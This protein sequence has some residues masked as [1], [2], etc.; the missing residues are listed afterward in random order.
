M[1]CDP[2]NDGFFVYESPCILRIHALRS[3]D[4]ERSGI[5][6][7]YYQHNQLNSFTRNLQNY[8]FEGVDHNGDF[9]YYQH[10]FF[11]HN[12]DILNLIST[13]RDDLSHNYELVA[14]RLKSILEDALED[15]QRLPAFD[16]ETKLEE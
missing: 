16:S 13:S 6:P 4:L 10:P 2:R 9:R 11:V 5:L 7:E 14:A 15:L 8:C 3:D 1:I 12:P